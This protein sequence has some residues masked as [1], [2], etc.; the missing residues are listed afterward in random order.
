MKLKSTKTGDS[1]VFRDLLA[2]FKDGVSVNAISGACYSGL[3]VDAIRETA[4]RDRYISA[5]SPRNQTALSI[6]RSVS[7][8]IRNS[9]F[10]QAFV[11]SL[12][13]MALPGQT[14]RNLKWDL[15]DHETWM[16]EQ[17]T[18]NITPNGTPTE[19]QSFISEPID[20]L[21]AL[22]DL[23]FRDKIDICYDPRVSARRRRIEW[24]VLDDTTLT[25]LHSSIAADQG[26]VKEETKT[27]IG[28]EVKKCDAKTDWRP[29]LIIFDEIYLKNPN[30]QLIL[31]NLYWRG[32]RQSAVWDTFFLLLNQGFFHPSCLS[33]PVQLKSSSD[34]SSK[35]FR[36]L[37]CFEYPSTDGQ[38][39]WADKIPLQST[40]WNVDLHW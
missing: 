18:R 32:R 26:I 15:A 33:L 11:Q 40:E 10:S 22:E 3:F 24:P 12:A 34:A 17:L 20:P 9:R 25:S 31:R 38:L 37:L 4:Q 1:Y 39:I 14:R 28:S 7:N 16:K 8:R 21:V 30:W 23:I 13:Q 35:V 29:D 36:L 19:P 6:T 27:L 5:A 2:G